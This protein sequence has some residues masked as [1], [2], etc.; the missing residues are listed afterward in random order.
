[1]HG[2]ALF[3]F[4]NWPVLLEKKQNTQA[5]V[6]SGIG[7]TLKPCFFKWEKR[8]RIIHRRKDVSKKSV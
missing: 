1:M 2:R 5:V 3:I 4:C 6:G 7:H 8:K